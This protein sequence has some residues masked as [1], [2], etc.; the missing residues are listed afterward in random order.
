MPKLE[1]AGVT[2]KISLSQI[3][4]TG[5]VRKE[6]Q[7]IEELAKSIKDSGLMQPIVV[8]RAGVTDSGIQQYEL[9]AGHRRKRAFGKRS[10]SRCR[11]TF[12]AVPQFKQ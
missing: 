1:P 10:A 9:I 12:C 8:K 5:N 7:D 2:Q 11:T 6:Y 4:E 3:I